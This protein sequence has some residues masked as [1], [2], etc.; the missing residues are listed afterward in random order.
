MQYLMLSQPKRSSRM[1]DYRPLPDVSARFDQSILTP[2]RVTY[3]TFS[4][5]AWP[6]LRGQLSVYH[7]SFSISLGE[8]HR[9]NDEIII[10]IVLILVA[11]C[12]SLQ[13]PKRWRTRTSPLHLAEEP[14]C[15][16]T[17]ASVLNSP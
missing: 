3:P 4:R 2:R 12:L 13:S 8:T 17:E 15:L 7:Y 16:K 1:P 11:K 14:A 6:I 9:D 10:V 5:V